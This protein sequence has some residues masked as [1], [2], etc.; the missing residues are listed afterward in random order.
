MR[1]RSRSGRP[2]PADQ[3]G[4]PDDVAA[5]RFHRSP[6][7]RSSA[8]R[9]DRSEE[10]RDHR[11]DSAERRERR[12]DPAAGR[13]PVRIDDPGAVLERTDRT[14]VLKPA[15]LEPRRNQV[16]DRRRRGAGREL[17]ARGLAARRPDRRPW[18]LGRPGS[19]GAPRRDPA[20]LGV[21]LGRLSAAV[22]PMSSGFGRV[23][24]T[25]G[26]ADRCLGRWRLGDVS[27]GARRRAL[28]RPA[29]R[30]RD[31][32]GDAACGQERAATQ[33]RRLSRRGIAR[34]VAGAH[35]RRVRARGRKSRTPPPPERRG[36]RVRRRTRSPEPA[37]RSTRRH[38]GAVAR[39]R[40]G[41]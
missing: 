16:G 28:S 40:S 36:P 4:R 41:H 15:L 22:R 6:S 17:A 29:A 13:S 14:T 18:R 9:A 33:E 20:P 30:R 32:A 38:R 3:Q 24:G 23:A 35:R 10:H 34:M 27:G 11:G 7:G 31:G 21:G 5:S 2:G 19:V 1:R 26:R 37:A 25:G 12:L 8:G 39:R